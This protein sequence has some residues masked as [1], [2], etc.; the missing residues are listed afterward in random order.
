VPDRIKSSGYIILFVGVGLLVFTFLNAY[1]FLRGVLGIAASPDLTEVFGQSLAPLIEACIRAI[2]LGIMGWIG[3]ILTVRGVHFFSQIRHE[4]K[5]EAKPK[6]EAP[7]QPTVEP[8][9]QPTAENTSQS[10]AQSIAQTTKKA[11]KKG[12]KE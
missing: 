9:P 4:A 3:S 12:K 11:A 10:F 5:A 1:L 8:S 2:Y 6:T 7:A